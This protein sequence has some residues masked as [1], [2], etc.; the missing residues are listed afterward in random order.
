[1]TKQ[2]IINEINRIQVESSKKVVDVE[3]HKLHTDF[4]NLTNKYIVKGG[5][6]RFYIASNTKKDELEN[7]LTAIINACYDTFGMCY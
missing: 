1:M 7:M 4:H 3:T 2:Q 5:Y 6:K